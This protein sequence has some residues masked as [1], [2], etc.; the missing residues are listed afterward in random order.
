[1]V[2]SLLSQSLHGHL[3]RLHTTMFLTGVTNHFPTKSRGWWQLQHTGLKCSRLYQ[4]PEEGSTTTSTG[5]AEEGLPRL[6]FGSRAP[7]SALQEATL[8]R[9]QHEQRGEALPA[10]VTKCSKEVDTGKEKKRD[11][12]CREMSVCGPCAWEYLHYP[13]VPR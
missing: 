12:A 6:D 13:P 11:V 8:A 1:M 5:Q 10:G 2:W 4:S 9:P 3:D 7:K